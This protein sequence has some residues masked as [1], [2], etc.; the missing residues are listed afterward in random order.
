MFQL[1]K[2]KNVISLYPNKD[3]HSKRFCY[4]SFL[5]PKEH[6]FKIF[7]IQTEC[8]PPVGKRLVLPFCTLE[9][10]SDY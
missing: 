7:S 3:D 4:V 9:Y 1:Y 2:T 10:W 8:F 5:A 6:W